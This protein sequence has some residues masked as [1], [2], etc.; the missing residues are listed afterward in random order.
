MRPLE[1]KNPG[2]GGRTGA[3]MVFRDDG[4]CNHSTGN[5]TGLQAISVK[6]ELKPPLPLDPKTIIRASLAFLHPDG[7]VFELCIIGPKAPKN[8]AWEGYAGSKKAIVAGWFRDHDKAAVLAVQVKAEGVYVTLNPCQEALLGR[9]N[10]RLKAHVDRTKD[11][12]ISHIKNLLIDLDP[13]RPTGISSTDAEHEAAL[14]MAQIIRADLEKKGWPAP[15]VG[16]SGNGAHLT[17]PLDLPHSEENIALLKAV[18]VGLIRRYADQLTARG[19]ELDQAVFNPARLTKLYGTWT[20]KG[21]KTADRPHRL[22]K[23]IFLPETRTPVP[24][25]LLKTIAQEA[26][27]QET[28]GDKGDGGAVDGNFNLEA[29]LN[30]YNVDVV[31]VKP[32]G[33]GCLYCLEQCLFD[34]SHKGNE[35]AIGQAV[36]GLLYYQCFHNSC[37]DRTWAEARQIISGTDNLWQFTNLRDRKPP[38]GGAQDG[39]HRDL[40]IDMTRWPVM[41]SEAFHGLAGE[42]VHLVEP[43][44]ESDQAA[45]LLQF[46]IGFGNLIGKGAYAKVEADTHYCNLFT[47]AVGETSKGR[48]GTSWGQVRGPLITVDPGWRGRVKSGLSSGEGLIFHVRDQ[49]IKR[50]AKQ[51][52]GQTVY[53]DEITDFGEDDKRLLVVESEFANVLRQIERQGNILSSVAR[54]A[55]DTGDLGTLT[56]NSPTKATGAH[57]SIIG[58]ITKG[59]LKRYLTRTEAGN[60]FGNRI[61]WFC[62]KRSKVLPEGGQLSEVDFAPFLSR[63]KEA[64]LF[65][66][67]AGEV[68]RTPEARALWAKVYP[69]LSEG[70]PGLVG[71]LTS[72]AEAQVLRLSMIYALLDRES[73]VRVHHLLAALAVWDYCEASVKYIFGKTIG[74]PV[75]DTILAAVKASPDG[76]TRTEV[77]NLFGRHE[78]SGN[79]Q[80]AIGELLGRDFVVRKMVETGG[81]PTE[82]LRCKGAQ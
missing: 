22:A 62:V 72:R 26:G 57:V 27:D 61:L 17:F 49:V 82:K 7:E 9:A 31:K 79:I 80:R 16:D 32:H 34:P 52:R 39:E 28:P 5:H 44:T 63:L 42:F 67:C 58:H 3:E 24:I 12:E 38:P 71:A 46:H 53:E 20:G 65:A 74:D 77:Y 29:Y 15:L 21:D 69:D 13:I 45:L 76:L 19:L 64:T 6:S 1:M 81:R 47:V 54:D 30:H 35:A 23:I 36:S 43:H 75:A 70:K 60:G 68:T 11:A 10:E 2:A 14:D 59:E 4:L 41:A 48:K 51:V 37:Q 66:Q 55:W 25:E 78:R 50:V 8:T 73:C 40:G 33:G 18:L 56:K